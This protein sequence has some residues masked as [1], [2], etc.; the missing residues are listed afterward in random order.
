MIGLTVFLCADGVV[1]GKFRR[2]GINPKRF[3][4]AKVIPNWKG[5]DATNNASNDACIYPP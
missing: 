1:S 4:G 2:E 5:G 3:A